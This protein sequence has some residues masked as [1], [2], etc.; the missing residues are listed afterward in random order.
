MDISVE[1]AKEMLE[2]GAAQAEEL[3]K[4]P[5]RIGDLLYDLETRLKETPVIGSAVAD[6]TLMA[7]MVRGYVTGEYREVSPKVIATMVAA[8]LYI[9]K[10]DDL[11][12]DRIPLV[13]IADD[14]AVLTLALKWCEPELNAY[15]KWKE[16]AGA[17][18]SASVKGEDEEMGKINDFLT[19]AG[20]F[21]LATTDGDQP[22][23]RPLGLHFEKDGKVYFGVGE[24][25]NVCLQL[26]TNPKT[27][28]AACKADGHWLRYTGRVVFDTDPAYTEAAF[29]AM[30]DLRKIYNEQ[31]GNR[32]AVFHLEDETAVDIPMMG[33]GESLL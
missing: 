29:E 6:I 3:M 18:D 17:K 11:I 24:S 7:G 1:A 22:K 8:F 13:G 15:E 20:T 30:P 5:A 2:R 31:T 19:E 33:E 21:F 10:K 25:K 9:V 14:I 28:I 4:D 26:K 23:V 27:E 16:G 12:P 32:L